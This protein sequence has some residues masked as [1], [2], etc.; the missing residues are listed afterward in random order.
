ME[1]FTISIIR[2]L[3]STALLIIFVWHVAKQFDSAIKLIDAHL[4]QQNE[5]LRDCIKSRKSDG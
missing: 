4:R 2:D 5:L 1:D 3:P